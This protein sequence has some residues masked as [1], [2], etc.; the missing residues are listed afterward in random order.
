MEPWP[1]RGLPAMAS[2]CLCRPPTRP[3]SVHFTHVET[4]A[5]VGDTCL[6]QRAGRGGASMERLPGVQA[7]AWLL[8]G[9]SSAP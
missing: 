1:G 9:G 4:E 7:G 5:Q 2:S 6:E 8:S 3:S